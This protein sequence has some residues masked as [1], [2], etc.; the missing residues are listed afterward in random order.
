[1]GWKGT[2]RSVNASI[3]RVQREQ[4]K[5]RKLEL[6]QQ[7]FEDSTQQT[8]DY[9]NYL[10]KIQSLHTGG[11]K[12]KN[13]KDLAFSKGPLEPKK[14][15]KSEDEARKQLKNFSPSFIDKVFRLSE[16][17]KQKLRDQI[18]YA[19]EKD[20]KD[21]LELIKK[22]QKEKKNYLQIKKLAEEVLKNN[23]E[24]YLTVLKDFLQVVF[25]V[26][27]LEFEI[28]NLNQISCNIFTLGDE[29]V[30][31]KR[32][33]VLRSGKLSVTELPKGQFNKIYQ[34]FICSVSLRIARDVYAILPIES[35]VINVRAPVVNS[36][37]G[38]LEDSILLSVMIPKKTLELI[39]LQN[40]D[41]S[42]SMKNFKHNMK[43][44]TTTG[45]STVSELAR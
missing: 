36:T 16:K 26:K 17:K 42:D 3:K 44:K 12:R 9:E 25:G 45:L 5:Q 10:N 30:P 6:K 8:T 35:V 13:W 15:S 33:K 40:L 39:N 29:I 27:K 28:L 18:K 23:K 38:H 37:T 4:E 2:V 32:K 21:H 43:F 11:L 19:I 34:D 31:T 24:A 7:I 22:F 1:M 20:H 14:L 41:A